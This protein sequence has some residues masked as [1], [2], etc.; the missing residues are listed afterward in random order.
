MS[1]E[2]N[3]ETVRAFAKGQ[4][5]KD[6]AGVEELLA[7]DATFFPGKRDVKFEGRVA[8]TDALF[9]W[10]DSHETLSLNVVN[11]FYT[12]DEGFNEWH[13]T[14]KTKDGQDVE[15]HGVDYFKLRDG[16][17]LVKSS[18]RKV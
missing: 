9:A 7:E 4:S 3:A 15:T 6:R 8:F 5:N 11:E 17:I 10:L 18:F 2:K 1:R 14:G 13:F 12:D 16:K